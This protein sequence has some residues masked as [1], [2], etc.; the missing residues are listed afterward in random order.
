MYTL[1]CACV[2][3]GAVMLGEDVL[4]AIYKLVTNWLRR[5]TV[6][7]SPVCSFMCGL[8]SCIQDHYRHCIPVLSSVPFHSGAELARTPQAMQNVNGECD[9]SSPG[10]RIDVSVKRV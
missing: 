5:G 9:C 1:T 10:R 8:T 2:R 7:I 6:Y 3:N 4:V